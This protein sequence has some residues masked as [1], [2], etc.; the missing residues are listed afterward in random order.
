MS[1]SVQTFVPDTRLVFV[2]CVRLM[3][4]NGL[5]IVYHP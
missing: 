4:L 1:V 5:Y 2:W 3:I